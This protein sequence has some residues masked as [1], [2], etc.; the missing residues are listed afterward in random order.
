MPFPAAPARGRMVR[1][2]RSAARAQRRGM[3]AAP[4]G[5]APCAGAARI[6]LRFRSRGLPGGESAHARR[7]ISE[8]CNAPGR[9]TERL[10]SLLAEARAPMREL[11]TELHM[12]HLS[13][14]RKIA[15]LA[16]GLTLLTIALGTYA[17]V[18][19]NRMKTEIGNIADDAMPGMKHMG[20]LAVVA[21]EMRGDILLHVLS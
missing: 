3:D 11:R 12:N 18:A 16:A 6:L 4:A 20:K 1:G 9:I 13:I 7:H 8:G 10:I 5:A 14:S 17:F 15:A 19:M 21:Q 2:H